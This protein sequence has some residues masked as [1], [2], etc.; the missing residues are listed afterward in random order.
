MRNYQSLSDYLN[1]VINKVLHK[2][3]GG[4][5]YEV[6]PE[7]E[8]KLRASVK[9]LVKHPILDPH[10][11][12]AWENFHNQDQG[13]TPW[14]VAYTIAHVLSYMLTA[15]YTKR[16]TIEGYYIAGLL[17]EAGIMTKK[18]ASIMRSVK[19]ITGYSQRIGIKDTEKNLYNIKDCEAHERRATKDLLLKGFPVI[20][21]DMIGSPMC[22]SRYVLRDVPTSRSGHAFMGAPSKK[23]IT[24]EDGTEC[25]NG[26]NSWDNYGIPYMNGKGRSGQFHIEVEHLETLFTP[27]I[28]LDVSK[29]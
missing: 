21:G 18:G 14:C 17:L 1:E 23:V 24:I 5:L 13:R 16:I 10:G 8:I 3:Q 19:Y 20:F 2:R 27:W 6:V 9:K 11:E 7:D 26:E 25:L 15:K 22:D 28:F 29:V 4:A 12:L